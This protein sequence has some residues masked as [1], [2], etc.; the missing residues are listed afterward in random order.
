[1]EVDVVADENKQKQPDQETP[2]SF[3]A[4]V[5]LTGL[6]GGILWSAVGILA[7]FF[8]LTEIHP[9][10]ILEP[11]A[12]GDWKK[13][14]LGTVISLAVI[15]LISIG[16][17]F[18][19]YALFKK[20]KSIWAGFGYGIALFAIV[21]FIFNPIFPSIK[22]LGALDK[23]TIITSVCLY[24]LYGVFIGFSISYEESEQNLQKKKNQQA[25]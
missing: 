12:L 13:G 25:T 7:H 9:R 5:I 20:F 1:M 8:H 11:W 2:L 6:F 4:M 18:I 14:W 24:I 3:M 10:V 19:Y 22:P 15:G 21:F 16:V 17:A 23:N